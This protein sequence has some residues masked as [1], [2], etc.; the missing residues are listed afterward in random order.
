MVQRRKHENFEQSN[1]EN[2]PIVDRTVGAVAGK[3][4]IRS[5]TGGNRRVIERFGAESLPP[6][7][8]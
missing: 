7:N 8:D 3:A 5:E 1:P 4:G 2:H 6:Y